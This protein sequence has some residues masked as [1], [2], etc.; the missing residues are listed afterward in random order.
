LTLRVV[1]VMELTC[2]S[3]RFRI[4]SRANCAAMRSLCVPVGGSETLLQEEPD[5]AS[6]V[7]V[8][9]TENVVADAFVEVDCLKI[10]GVDV[11]RLSSSAPCCALD[12]SHE[13]GPDTGATVLGGHPEVADEEQISMRVARCSSGEVAVRSPV[14]R[15]WPVV[16]GRCDEVV[17]GYEFLTISR[18]NAGSGLSCVASF[19]PLA[20]PH[21]ATHGGSAFRHGCVGV[22]CQSTSE[23]YAGKRVLKNVPSLGSVHPA[24]AHQGAMPGGHRRVR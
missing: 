1:H 7:S 6:R 2:R 20:I 12:R 21:D 8:M 9:L 18:T 15:E 23:R 19:R 4:L 13:L 3:K 17:R 16:F 5:V 24:L 14:D 10:V 11:C 22:R